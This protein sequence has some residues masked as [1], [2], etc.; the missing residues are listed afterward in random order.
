[1]IRFTKGPNSDTPPNDLGLVKPI[2][3]LGERVV[4]TVA[5]AAD[6]ALDTGFGE[7]LIARC[8]GFLHLGAFLDT[9]ARPRDRPIES[10]KEPGGDDAALVRSLNLSI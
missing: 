5:D 4:V 8:T 3:R 1:M 7:T 6:R 2:D 10:P 9:T